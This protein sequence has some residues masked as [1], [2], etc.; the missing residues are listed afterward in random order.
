MAR[1][2]TAEM[3][4]MDFNPG[5]ERDSVE[6]W[7]PYYWKGLTFI[8][9][10]FATRAEQSIPVQFLT[11][12]PK[13]RGFKF[14][15]FSLVAPPFKI[16]QS[17]SSEIWSRLGMLCGLSKS[18]KKQKNCR[19]LKPTQTHENP[20]EISRHGFFMGSARGGNTRGILV[21]S[22]EV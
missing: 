19:R 9:Q 1:W 6:W 15:V 18:N 13:T 7:L 4:W 16:L 8:R 17:I 21:Y 3:P 10:G 20:R 12:T 2:A 5:R 22:K 14:S 11:L